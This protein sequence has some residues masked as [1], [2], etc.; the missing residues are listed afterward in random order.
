MHFS[1]AQALPALPPFRQQAWYPG[2][3]SGWAAYAGQLG[4]EIGFY[5]DPVIPHG[6]DRTLTTKFLMPAV[7]LIQAMAFNLVRFSE[8]NQHS[9]PGSRSRL[10]TQAN[11]HF[12]PIK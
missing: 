1:I 9:W 2:Y 12:L 5:Q 10:Y 6:F 11:G 7:D 8:Q 4:R 3:Q